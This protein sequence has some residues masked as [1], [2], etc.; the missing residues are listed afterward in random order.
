MFY[1]FKNMLINS[2]DQIN[3]P[4]MIYDGL[5]S[6]FSRATNLIYSL[7]KEFMFLLMAE[8]SFREI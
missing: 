2:F 5:L 7:L 6:Y 3:N 1:F 4:T 8:V